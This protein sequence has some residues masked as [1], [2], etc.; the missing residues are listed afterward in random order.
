MLI[1]THAHLFFENLKDHLDEV[2]E[3]ASSVDLSFI[4]NIGVDLDTSLE[5]IQQAKLNKRQVKIYSTI[6][7]HPHD[8]SNPVIN[9]VNIQDY[10][11]K[12]KQIYLESKQFI[13]GIG[14]CGLDFYREV[15]NQTKALQR[16]V[17]EK[18][19][20]LAKELNL[21]L[22]IHCRDALSTG[23]GPSA[24]DEMIPYLNG[25]KGILHCFS[26]NSEVTKK[27][28]QSDLY[29][30]FAANITYPKNDYLRE[31]AKLIPLDRLLIET[32]SP[33]L[34]P[35]DKRGETNEPANVLEVAK[36]LAEIKEVSLKE[37]SI[38]TS[39]N[40]V[41]IFNL[42]AHESANIF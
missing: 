39:R 25:L 35:Q 40:A 14:E 29:I 11:E 30:S 27:V 1:D 22:I 15:N 34:S 12:L 24:W 21:P 31:S 6:G 10:I 36:C 20:D 38:Q 42:P 4:I 16:I 3:N 23:S 26:G 19:I 5:A 2:L 8:S 7:L 41:Q 9:E 18:Q 17:F 33:F 13:V 28:L 32:D 37:V